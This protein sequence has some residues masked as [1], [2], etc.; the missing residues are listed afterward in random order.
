MVEYLEGHWA[1]EVRV[2]EPGRL[3]ALVAEWVGVVHLLLDRQY[4]NKAMEWDL[5]YADRGDDGV[6][7][8]EATNTGIVAKN[9]STEFGSRQCLP[10]MCF[11]KPHVFVSLGKLRVYQAGLGRF[12][13]A[14]THSIIPWPPLS[15]SCQPTAKSL[16]CSPLR[17]FA[18]GP[19]SIRRGTPPCAPLARSIAFWY[20][21]WVFWSPEELP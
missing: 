7:Y 14:F 15:A 2:G 20:Q 21:G 1:P 8:L 6:R 13:D 4:Q 3:H 18:N 11:A 17:P 9:L 10:S 5:G 12:P 19:S 16:R